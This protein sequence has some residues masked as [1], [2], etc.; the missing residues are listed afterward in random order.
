MRRAVLDWLGDVLARLAQGQ[1][2]SIL[3]VGCGPRP[4]LAEWSGRLPEGSEALVLDLDEAAVQEAAVLIP[5]AR[6]VCADAARLPTEQD[7]RFHLA[8]VGRPD[9]ALRPLGW[10]G[11]LARLARLLAPNGLAALIATNAAEAALATRWLEAAGFEVVERRAVFSPYAGWLIL[12]S[13]AARPGEAGPEPDPGVLVWEGEGA[14][15][16]AATGR[17]SGPE[18]V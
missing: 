11:T 4:L 2:L 9:L 10:Q 3:E 8:L 13:R 17:C 1:P 12:A 15:C 5:W 7:G 6:C 16:D 18:E 14:M